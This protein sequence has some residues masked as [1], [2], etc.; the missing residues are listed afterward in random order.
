MNNDEILI[1]RGGEVLSLLEG[2]ERELIDIVG[3]AYQAHERGDSSLPHST[4]LRFPES[5]SDRIIAL[6]A[7][8]G[9]EFGVAGVKWVSS[10]PGNLARGMDRA[11][12]VVILNSAQTGRP[13]AIVEGS[14]IS[15]KRTAASAALA[16]ERLHASD[17]EGPTGII[18][19]GLINFEVVK[20][21]LAARPAARTF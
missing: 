1:L 14:I 18:G 3:R 16:A 9:Q 21:L 12:A 19:T 2:Q 8:L 4:F 13:E 15:A 17:D 20:S 7:Y 5:E 11:S 10:F 6:P